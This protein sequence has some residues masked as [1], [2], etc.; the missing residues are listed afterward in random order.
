MNGGTLFNRAVDKKADSIFL[1]DR[2]RKVTI[3]GGNRRRRG[4][5]CIARRCAHRARPAENNA[6]AHTRLMTP[7]GQCPII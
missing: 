6:E 1:C 2:L 3:A 4:M 7:P 5:F